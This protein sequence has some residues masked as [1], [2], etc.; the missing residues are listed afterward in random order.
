MRW[1]WKKA[2]V[3]RLTNNQ[4]LIYMWE[5]KNGSMPAPTWRERLSSAVFG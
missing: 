1:P 3:T 5:L 2:T 4:V